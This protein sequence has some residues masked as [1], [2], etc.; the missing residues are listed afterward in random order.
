M[1]NSRNKLLIPAPCSHTDL[2][3]PDGA[4]LPDLGEKQAKWAVSGSA[5]CS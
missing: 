5:G 1:G 3:G 4:L 2:C